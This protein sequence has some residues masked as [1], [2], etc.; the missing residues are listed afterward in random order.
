MYNGHLSIE[1]IGQLSLQNGL[2]EHQAHIAN[3]RQCHE[4]LEKY[5]A[6]SAKLDQLVQLRAGATNVMNCPDERVWLDVAGGTLSSEESL[7]YV[8]HA[9][10]CASCAH[11]L[12]IA[13]R[14][15]QDELSPEEESQLDALPGAEVIG[16]KRLAEKLAHGISLDSPRAPIIPKQRKRSFGVLLSVAGAAAV[17]A[18]VFFAIPRNS[19]AAV[20]KLLA[21]AYTENRTIEMRIPYAKYAEIRQRR[22]GDA[23]SLLNT[24]A[25]AREAAGKIAAGL[26]RQPDNPQWLILQAQLDLLDW[27]YQPALQTLS[28]IRTGTDGTDFLL[29]R[30]LALSEQGSVEHEPQLQAEAVE[31][32]AEVLQKDG[33][34]LTALYNRALVCEDLHMYECASRD[35]QAVLQLDKDPGWSAEARRRLNRIEEKKTPER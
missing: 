22:S 35:W 25:A 13:I 30:A 19:P 20:Q 27:R 3:C 10:E 15:F 31:L 17:V 2:A 14:I 7:K 4:L 1:E 5:Q 11:K 16:R 29:A 9:A 34:N 33:N 23:G 8:Q 12:R 21:E 32:L 28:Q 26:K 18:I 24:P 6:V